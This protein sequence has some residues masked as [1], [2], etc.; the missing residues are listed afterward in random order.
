ME[1]I[2]VSRK[3]ERYF[4][5]AKKALGVIAIIVGLLGLVFPIL[6]GWI[7]IFVGLE[8]LGIQILFVE[9][10]KEYVKNKIKRGKRNDKSRN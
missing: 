9:R 2:K 1:E 10:I 8:L 5:I 4:D 7:L 3:K 6:P